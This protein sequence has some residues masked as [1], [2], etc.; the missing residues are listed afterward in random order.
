M[1]PGKDARNPSNPAFHRAAGFSSQVSFLQYIAFLTNK[2]T[3]TPLYICMQAH[4]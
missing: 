2:H 4:K 1:A 3:Y